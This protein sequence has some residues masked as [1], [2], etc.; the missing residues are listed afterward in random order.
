MNPIRYLA[1]AI[2]V[3][4]LGA[5]CA[6]VEEPG[7]AADEAWAGPPISTERSCFFTS[8]VNGYGEAPDGPRGGER[9]YVN[10]GV[11]DRYVLETF[12][13]CPDLDWSFRI[14]LDTRLQSSL[15]VGDTATVVVPRSIGGG[16]DRC[17]ARVI[18]RVIEQ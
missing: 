2:P 9:L 14:G 12:G 16:P 8:Q 17:T 11:R 1:A 18:G 10:T 13:P 6:P 15:C 5:A 4:A 7:A 3:A